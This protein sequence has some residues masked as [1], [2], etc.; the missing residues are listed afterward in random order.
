M[1]R[2]TA[3]D[4]RNVAAKN[5][6]IPQYSFQTFDRDRPE[7]AMGQRV[8]NHAIGICTPKIMHDRMALAYERLG[9][10][11]KVS[12]LDVW[13]ALVRRFLNNIF[14]HI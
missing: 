11:D 6:H 13:V 4:S 14:Q 2:R 7:I 10:I 12:G 5:A 8:T 3:N 9:A 1:S